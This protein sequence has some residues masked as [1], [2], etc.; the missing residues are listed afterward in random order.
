MVIMRGAGGEPD[1]HFKKDFIKKDPLVGS[2]TRMPP[3]CLPDASQVPPRCHPDGSRCIQMTPRCLADAT[4][5]D[6]NASR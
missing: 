1:F 2:S 3:R 4:Q 6:P 5:M